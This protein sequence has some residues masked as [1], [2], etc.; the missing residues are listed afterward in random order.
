[1]AM[2]GLFLFRL[3]EPTA[4]QPTLQ[5]R[6]ICQSTPQICCCEGG[7]VSDEPKTATWACAMT[8]HLALSID[9]WLTT[10]WLRRRWLVLAKGVTCL[11]LRPPGHIDI[12]VKRCGLES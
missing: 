3:P 9:A 4:S 1:M 12:K 6:R 8:E 2:A 7:L 5:T 10:K 11:R